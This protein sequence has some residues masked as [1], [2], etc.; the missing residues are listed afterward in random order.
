MHRSTSRLQLFLIVVFTALAAP[1]ARP[2]RA[3]APPLLPIVYIAPDGDDT[4]DCAT[5]ASRCATLQR[6]FGQLAEGGE[7]RLAGGSYAGATELEHSA[8][9]AGG[10]ALP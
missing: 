6:A 10:Y 1:A 4:Q 2:A 5:P 8:T 7:A 9:I 3:T